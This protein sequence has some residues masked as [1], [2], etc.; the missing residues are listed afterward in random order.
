[1]SKERVETYERTETY[2]PEPVVHCQS[3]LHEAKKCVVCGQILTEGDTIGCNSETVSEEF[4]IKHI[5]EN[6]LSKR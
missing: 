4:Q 1:M 2:I 3:C 5:C 6:C